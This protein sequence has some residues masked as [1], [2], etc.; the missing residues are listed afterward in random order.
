VNQAIDHAGKPVAG[1]Q[2][3]LAIEDAQQRLRLAQA[4]ER[5]GVEAPLFG[6]GRFPGA[7][8]RPVQ[9][10]TAMDSDFGERFT[11]NGLR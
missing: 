11:V 1:R 6:A 8:G 9:A 4:S 7:P 3:R 10:V 2:I 5:D